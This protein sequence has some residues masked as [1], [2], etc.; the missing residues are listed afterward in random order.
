VTPARFAQGMTWTE[1]AACL[2]TPENLARE[3]FDVRRFTAV[4]P[5][6]DWSGYRLFGHLRKTG[7]DIGA[8]FASPLYDGWASAAIDEILSALYERLTTRGT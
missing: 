2:G 5:R 1:Y 4:R 7:G 8:V 6:I 3:G